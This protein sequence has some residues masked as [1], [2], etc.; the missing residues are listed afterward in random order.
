MSQNRELVKMVGW[1]LDRM[2]RPMYL[3]LR[4]SPYQVSR[5][6]SAHKGIVEAIRK[7]DPAASRQALMRDIIE[8]QSAAFGKGVL[9][10]YG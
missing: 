1:I 9:E 4:S 2:Q 7:R 8:A 6:L 3:E 10:Q 5:S